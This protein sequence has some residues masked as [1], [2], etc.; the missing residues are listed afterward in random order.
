MNTLIESLLLGCAGVLLAWVLRRPLRRFAGPGPA[1]CLWLLPALLAVMP[2][3]PAWST[4]SASGTPLLTLPAMLVLP[5]TMATAAPANAPVWLYVWSSGCFLMLLRLA[6]YY[7]RIVRA[8]RPLPAAMGKALAPYPRRRDATR[9][10]LHP[11]GPAALWGLRC[12][13]LLPADF[14]QRFDAGERT[15]VLTHEFTHLRRADP[16]WS[17]LAEMALAALWFFPPAWLAMSRFR[18]DQELAC[19]AA[20]LRDSPDLAGSYARAL[21][22]SNRAQAAIPA[23][24]PWLSAPQLKERLTMIHQQHT[25]LHRL[26][27]YALLAVLLAGTAFVGHAALP[28]TSMAQTTAPATSD[29]VNPPHVLVLLPA[30]PAHSTSAAVNPASKQQHPPIYP[31]EAKK[32]NQQGTVVLRL[33]VDAHGNV[34]KTKINKSSG[35][36]SLDTAAINAAKQWKFTP[37]IR[38]GKP[39]K[40][41]LQVPVNFSLN[42]NAAPFAKKIEGEHLSVYP[43]GSV[44]NHHQGTVVLLV[45]VDASGKPLGT[46]IKQSSGDSSLDNAAAKGVMHEKFNPPTTNGKPHAGWLSRYITFNAN[47]MYVIT[48][49]KAPITSD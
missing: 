34:Q 18:L 38:N 20:V 49:A 26:G 13:V 29:A 4:V 36:K 45:R 9:L 33:L 16:L 22:N 14:L 31:K 3:L 28:Q 39:V 10:R 44:K 15:Q 17:L 1:F 7:L 5:Q 42:E 43:E 6:L 48:K 19:D 25:R 12:R 46:K 41:W 8:M 47:K 40:A 30:H 2:W 37:A 32:Q 11:A 23:M 24:D 27:G 35:Y 21:L